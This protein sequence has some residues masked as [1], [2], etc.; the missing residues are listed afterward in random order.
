MM[1]YSIEIHALHCQ[2][3]GNIGTSSMAGEFPAPSCKQPA[4]FLVISDCLLKPD[5]V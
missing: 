2:I 1:S 4:I 3:F 5:N